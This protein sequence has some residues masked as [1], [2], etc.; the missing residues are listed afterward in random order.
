MNNKAYNEQ[1]ILN[2]ETIAALNEVDEMR[3]HPEQYPPYTSVDKMFDTLLSEDI[4]K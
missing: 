2:E 3:K 1:D 4:S